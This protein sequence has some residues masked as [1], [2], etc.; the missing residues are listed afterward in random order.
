MQELH[1]SQI[2]ASTVC[3]RL[4]PP[5]TKGALFSS[6]CNMWLC[7]QQSKW[8]KWD[9]KNLPSARCTQWPGATWC[10]RWSPISLFVNHMHHWPWEAMCPLRGTH[11]HTQAELDLSRFSSFGAAVTEFNHI[12][13]EQI[14]NGR[15]LLCY[16]SNVLLC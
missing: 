5:S 2:P 11:V 9:F 6:L 15:W 16:S 14:K 7:K 3:R 10:L 12:K 13:W 4:T 1:S 8:K